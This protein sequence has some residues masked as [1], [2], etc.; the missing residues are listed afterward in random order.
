MDDEITLVT[1]PVRRC[2]AGVPYSVTEDSEALGRDFSYVDWSDINEYSSEELTAMLQKE[3]VN[4][5]LNNN[6]LVALC[7]EGKDPYTIYVDVHEELHGLQ[8]T[9]R[10][11]TCINHASY[12]F[13]RAISD[14]LSRDTDAFPTSEWLAKGVNGV[15]AIVVLCQGEYYGHIYVWVREQTCS[16]I[17]IRSRIDLQF[18]RDTYTGI[19]KI[20]ELL[21]EGVRRF[22]LLSG[23]ERIVVPY[24][25]PNMMRILG[26]HGFK[27]T[28]IQ[29]SELGPGPGLIDPIYGFDEKHCCPNAFISDVRKV[30][31]ADIDRHLVFS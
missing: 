28:R 23:C 9:R 8:Y 17:G 22:A 25:L 2:A 20:S 30:P 29:H 6:L 13:Q 12:K 27:T 18:L 14:I 4:Y 3:I 10:A 11:N 15:H 24:P 7:E 1:F 5:A 16:A 31:Y 19:P 26:A 21:L